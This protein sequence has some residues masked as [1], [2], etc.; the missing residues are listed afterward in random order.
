MSLKSIYCGV[1]KLGALLLAGGLLVSCGR[2]GAEIRAYS[3]SISFAPAPV[4]TLGGTATVSASASSGLPVIFSTTTPGVCSVTSS[5][6]VIAATSAG[7]CSI[8]ANQSGNREFAPAARVTLNIAVINNRL[9][10]LSFVAAPA[11]TLYGTAQVPAS[12]SSG[13]TIS[14]SSIT[15]GVCSV[16]SLR[17]VVSSLAV[18]DCMIAANQSGDANYD[19]APQITQTLS[20]GAWTGSLSVPGSPG[21]VGATLGHV[22]NTVL[23]SFDGPS[24]S[25]GSPI[26]GYQVTSNPAGLSVTGAGSPLSVSCPSGCSGYAFL[27]AATNDGINYGAPASPVEVLTQFAVTAT[28]YEPDTQHEPDTQPNDSIFTGTFTLN[29]T[30]GSVSD[31]QGTLTESMTGPP[32]QTVS[33]RHQLSS[34]SDGQGGL[35]VTT[36][37][38][39]A[40]NTFYGGGFAPTSGSGLYYGYPNRQ[41][42]AANAYAMI[43]INPANPTATLTPAQLSRIAYADCTAGGMMGDVCMTGTSMAGYGMVGTMS[44]F[45]VS[46]TIT[47]Q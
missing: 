32:M 36:F 9:Q 34:Q 13:L 33:L 14:Y 38:L 18:G 3:Q 7:T 12:V 20:V 26:T 43:Y 17:G 31:L 19:A 29:S 8:V 46:Q 47:K 23:I 4:L 25:G 6:G 30:T 37:A 10:T 21:N 41:E 5:S 2:S 15:P 1:F 24:S 35:L 40:A 44:G 11:L 39:N 45:P 27:V 16:D 22:P 28:F 42:S